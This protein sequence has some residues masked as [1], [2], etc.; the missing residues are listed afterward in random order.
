ME[1]G[2]GGPV[3]HAS[4]ST[5]SLG[6]SMRTAIDVL[7]G[8]GDRALGEWGEYGTRALNIVHLRRRLSAA[9]APQVNE[10]RDIRGTPEQWERIAALLHDAPVLAP[11]VAQLYGVVGRR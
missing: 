6:L 5:P 10:L 11:A 1:R 7:A 8:V 4:V 3:W 2:F 9:E